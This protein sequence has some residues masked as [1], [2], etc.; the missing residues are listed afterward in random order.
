MKQHL[1]A[2]VIDTVE[3]AEKARAYL[4]LA[5]D[6]GKRTEGRNSRQQGINCLHPNF[7]TK[8]EVKYTVLAAE[9]FRVCGE[10]HY[11]DSAKC[12]SRAATLHADALHNPEEAA[13]LFTEAGIVSE[14]TDTSFA[15]EYYS[16]YH[17][18]DSSLMSSILLTYQ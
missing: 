17:N 8:Q 16:E 6:I 12:Y 14:K 3:S 4:K 11:F 10:H 7:Y 1:K 9:A 5:E 13:R 15:N 2:I 18:V